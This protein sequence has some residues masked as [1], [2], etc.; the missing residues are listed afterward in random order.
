MYEREI[1]EALRYL[2]LAGTERATPKLIEKAKRFIFL[3]QRI[4]AKQQEAKDYH[5]RVSSFAG[6]MAS[7]LQSLAPPLCPVRDILEEALIE[8][9][10]PGRAIRGLFYTP[11]N[12][13]MDFAFPA[14]RLCVVVG[15]VDDHKGKSLKLDG[16]AYIHFEEDAIRRDPIGCAFQVKQQYLTWKEVRSWSHK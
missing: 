7:F 8:V 5:D 13:V 11:W 2:G 9:H 1:A 15:E 4:H 6:H 14:T 10:I 3:Q 12:V 16:W